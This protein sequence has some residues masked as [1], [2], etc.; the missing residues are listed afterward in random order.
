MLHLQHIMGNISGSSSPRGKLS[1][2]G[3]HWD[4]GWHPPYGNRRVFGRYGKFGTVFIGDIVFCLVGYGACSNLEKK[5][6]RS[7]GICAL[8]I[9]FLFGDACKVADMTGARK[10]SGRFPKMQGSFTVE[11]A[12]VFPIVLFC[13]LTLLNQ[14]IELYC[15]VVEIIGNQAA[16]ESFDPASRFRQLEQLGHFIT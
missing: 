15:Q 7:D 16:W 6:E 14:G 4:G 10:G 12:L 1:K 5:G 2:P 11:A 9:G 3:R 8:F 13:I